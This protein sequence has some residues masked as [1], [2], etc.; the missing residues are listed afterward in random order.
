MGRKQDPEL[1]R[2]ERVR[3]GIVSIK[4]A[5][6]RAHSADPTNQLQRQLHKMTNGWAK[7]LEA[8]NQAQ[9]HLE[10]TIEA[11]E[12]VLELT[13]PEQL[14]L[15]FF[16]QLEDMLDREPDLTRERFE[17]WLDVEQTWPVEWRDAAGMGDTF[18]IATAEQLAQMRREVDEV[19][20]RYRRI[21]QGN[22]AAR[23]MAVYEI[24][25]PLDLDRA[26]RGDRP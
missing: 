19:V 26:P 3:D 4:A 16:E 22:P 15:A 21:G 5:L 9:I 17:R 20:A 23:R 13:P 11:G 10:S 14:H 1:R 24:A 8:C 12:D 6:T 25:Y 7:Q 2:L 18:V